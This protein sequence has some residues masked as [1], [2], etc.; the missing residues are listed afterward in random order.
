M[1][2]P[3]QKELINTF[4]SQVGQPLEPLYRELFEYLSELGYNPH[5]QRSYIIFKHTE[6]N[7]QIAK[8]G[9][10]INKDKSPFFN[11]RFSACRG[12]SKRFAD[13]VKNVLVKADDKP[14]CIFANCNFCEGEPESHVYKYEDKYHCGA[15]AFEIPNISEDD[16]CEIKN[17]IY[18]N[19]KYLMKNQAGI[20]I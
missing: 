6:H 5:K 12:Y 11:L 14:G 10:R 1:K 4:L 18:E 19:H 8:T 2:T 16:V 3:K 13:I 9:I 15:V 17:L 7:K 20:E